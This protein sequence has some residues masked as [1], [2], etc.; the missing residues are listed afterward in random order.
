MNPSDLEFFTTKEL[1]GELMRRKTFLGIVVHSEED[2]RGGA[3]LGERLFKVHFNSNLDSVQASRILETV[4]EFMD[5]N[6]AS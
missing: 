1:V 2:Y 3:W 5:Q 4:A 6:S